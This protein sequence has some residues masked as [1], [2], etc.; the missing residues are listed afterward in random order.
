[1][2]VQRPETGAGTAEGEKPVQALQRELDEA[3][4]KI[5]ELERQ[6]ED[7]SVAREVELSASEQE[8]AQ[9]KQTY[10]TLVKEL[11]QEVDSGKI[12]IEQSAG[13]VKLDIA[14][15]L[16]FETGMADIKPE[17]MKVLL[18]IG[19]DLQKVPRM[20][21]RVEG[22]TDNVP[23]GPSLKNDYPTNWE[24]AAA[25]AVNVVRFLQEKA[26]T[27]PRRLSAVSYAEY[28]PVASNKT[29]SGKQ[30][31]RRV[32]IVL[33]DKGIDT[34]KKTKTQAKK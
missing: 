9:V 27:D 29:E 16:F 5:A 7:I 31:N 17:G 24:L 20:N 18:R 6:I 34:A 21:I 13:E 3:H 25:R 19:K 33:I 8:L 32:E 12:K 14:E 4:V 30:R 22:H 2:K 15:E 11:K 26:G 28:R 1:M 10:E 23:I